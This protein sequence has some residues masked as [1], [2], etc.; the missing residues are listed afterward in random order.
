MNN[1]QECKETGKRARNYAIEK[2]GKY[3]SIR[4]YISLI[5]MYQ[6]IN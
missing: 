6:Y 1:P 5:E 4:K 3:V 2:A